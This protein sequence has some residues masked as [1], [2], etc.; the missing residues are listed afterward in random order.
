MMDCLLRYV[1]LCFILR[2]IEEFYIV[3]SLLSQ[4]FQ[5]DRWPREHPQVVLVESLP[6]PQMRELLRLGVLSYSVHSRLSK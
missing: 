1:H 4:P 6:H 2:K 3:V 5:H